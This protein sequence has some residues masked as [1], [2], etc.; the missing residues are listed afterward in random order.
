MGTYISDIEILWE[1]LRS[2]GVLI[3]IDLTPKDKE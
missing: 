3:T 1:E 2:Q